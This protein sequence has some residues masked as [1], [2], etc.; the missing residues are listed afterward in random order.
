MWELHQ[1]FEG[2]SKKVLTFSLWGPGRKGDCNKSCLMGRGVGNGETD[3]QIV[4]LEI[5]FEFWWL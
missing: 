4:I 3:R 1:G 2:K 5:M